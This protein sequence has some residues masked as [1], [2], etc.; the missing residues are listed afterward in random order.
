MS[1]KLMTSARSSLNR[2][3]NSSLSHRL[4]LGANLDMAALPEQF[5]MRAPLDR[6]KRTNE[7]TSGP[8]RRGHRQRD[9]TQRHF[10]GSLLLTDQPLYEAGERD[11]QR[12]PNSPF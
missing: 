10:L 7:K 2:R 5:A 12:Q 3:V 8:L 11:N 6:V 9:P 4:K 1:N